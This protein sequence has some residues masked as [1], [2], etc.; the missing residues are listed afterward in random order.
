[1]SWP[2]LRVLVAGG[3]IGGLCL[4]QGLRAAG[5][6]VRVFERDTSVAGR[7]QGYR[8]HISPEGE[9]ALR[10][11]LPERVVRLISGTANV[12]HGTGLSAYDEHLSPRWA[13]AFEDPRAADPQ[14][15]DSVDRVTLRHALLAGIEDV[16]QFGRTVVGH[17]VSPGGVTVRLA[18]GGTEAGDVL[19]AADGAGSRIRERH[20]GLASPADLGIR[21]IFGRIPMTPRVQALISPELRDRF[22]YVSGSDGHHLG[23]M[24]MVF[25]E[26]PPVVAGRLWP[27]LAMAPAGDYYMCV[28]NLHADRLGTSDDELFR[29]SGADLWRLVTERTAGWHP[30][31]REI[32]G[33][34]DPAASFAVA[35][36]ATDPVVPWDTG[37][38]IPLGDA[39]HTMPPSG[40]VGA[41]TAL[42]DAN[43]LTTALAGVDRGERDLADA[44][45]D[46]QAAMV[47]YAT[48]A[49]QLS[50][51]ILR[52]SIPSPDEHPAAH[53]RR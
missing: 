51:R 20:H 3:G 49:L 17:E 52:W 45:A 12:R 38:V 28:F 27:G 23:L 33:Y 9:R 24:P 42:R 2:G 18:D 4:A 30:G 6:S 16:V 7:N 34:A 26:P 35:L 10:E 22:S 44:V 11:C 5:V 53:P 37:P 15:I 32:L 25:R 31:V 13:P 39:A 41:N 48:D 19:V 21:T 47:G 8:L 29:L 1:V 50:L 43:A 46:Y 14:K 40:G 36:R